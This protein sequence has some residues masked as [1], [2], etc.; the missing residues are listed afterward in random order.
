M[1]LGQLYYASAVPVRHNAVCMSPRVSLAIR[2]PLLTFGI[3]DIGT[4]FKRSHREAGPYLLIARACGLALDT[5]FGVELGN[6]PHLWPPHGLRHQ[7]WY[8]RPSGVSGEVII[9]SAVNGLV[10][11]STRNI[12]DDPH[13]VMWE[14]HGEPWQRWRLTDVPDGGGYLLQSVYST[15]FLTANERSE[16]G[17]E[18]WFEDRHAYQSQQWVVAL[19]HGKGLR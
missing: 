11:D 6:K 17:W 7:L 14:Q 12:T 4:I 5:A 1:D 8:L 9:V 3:D 10:L 13:P 2:L 18:P 19:P 15:R 16:R